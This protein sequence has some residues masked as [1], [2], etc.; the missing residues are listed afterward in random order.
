MIPSFLHWEA[1][2]VLKHLTFFKQ[3]YA[4]HEGNKH[5]YKYVNNCRIVIQI[6]ADDA[7]TDTKNFQF[8][9]EMTDDTLV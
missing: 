1:V 4:K 5:I 8:H 6:F 9:I 2:Q 3:N 7:N